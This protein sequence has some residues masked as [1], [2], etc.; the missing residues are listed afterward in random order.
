MKPQLQYL[1]FSEFRMNKV[2]RN[3]CVFTLSLECYF[4]ITYKVIMF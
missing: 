3:I 4:N 2:Q 1:I